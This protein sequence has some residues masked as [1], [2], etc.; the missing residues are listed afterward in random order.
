M[1]SPRAFFAT[2]KVELVH[3]AAWATRAVGAHELF[4]YLE[5]FYNGPR[6]H[7]RS[8]SQPT[9]LR[10]AVG[11]RRI[12]SLNPRVYEIGASPIHRQAV[13]TRVV[14]TRVA[15]GLRQD[16]RE[17]GVRKPLLLQRPAQSADILDSRMSS[18]RA[19]TFPRR[20]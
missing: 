5:L 4:E 6:R 1:P 10:A 16:I 12:G 3:D 9:G 11:S 13:E 17:R 14:E 7:S 18:P 20:S 8:G 19:S 2:L 15:V